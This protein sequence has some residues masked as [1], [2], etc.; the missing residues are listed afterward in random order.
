MRQKSITIH[1]I[2]KR[3][4]KSLK[5]YLI[6]LIIWFISPHLT[7]RLMPLYLSL[8]NI[9]LIHYAAPPVVGG[10]EA[11]LARQAELLARAGHRVH[12]LAG[13]GQTWSASVP[14]EVLP[15][16]DS[17]H[18]RVL[19]VKSSLD[20]GT[21]PPEFS[22]LSAEIQEDLA[23]SLA[24]TDVLIAHN[25][26][27]L[28]KNL[29][30]TAALYR[31]SQTQTG[32]RLVLWH[33]DL[34]WT[35]P[36]YQADLHSGFPWDLLRST[37]PGAR[38]VV[39]SEARRAEL[40]GLLGIP[41]GEI[42]VVPSGLDL[43][44]FFGLGQFV[45]E[46]VDRFSLAEAAPLLLAPVRLT[47]RKNLE[48]AL[49][50][51]AALRHSFPQARLVITGP[52]G[53]HNPANAAYFQSLL[54]LRRSL[55]LDSAAHLLAELRPDGLTDPEIAELYRLAD[56]LLLPSREEGFGIP[57]LEAG[58][59]RLPIFCSDLPPLRDLAGPLA[60]YFS[61]D[62]PPERV[63]EV[64]AARLSGDPLYQM[65]A[66]IRSAYTWEAI[67]RQRIAPLL[68]VP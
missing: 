14:V 3:S 30:L 67:Y 43:A 64:I 15:L 33:H 37:W 23:A 9:V 54:D 65:R 55:G 38:Q 4:E 57:V 39:V 29:P 7:I 36:R 51:L 5:F 48:L 20:R 22:T 34:A 45:R 19:E 50:T 44:D 13:R 17:R 68:E 62:D 63:A 41:M 10:V 42:A 12:V 66:G 61:P 59:G 31:L 11:V 24:G 2:V 58:L 60:T 35:T 28:H 40:A 53:A 16:I 26:A 46:L 52:P 49:C 18:P 25:V 47:P 32:L 6:Y 1:S 21:V 56:A 8:V 27:S